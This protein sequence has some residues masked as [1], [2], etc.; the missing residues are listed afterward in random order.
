MLLK[1]SATPLVWVRLLL[2]EYPLVW[3]CLS[4]N[5]ER[6]STGRNAKYP[7]WNHQL[8]PSKKTECQWKY[9][10]SEVQ[11]KPDRN[12]L[13]ARWCPDEDVEL[14]LPDARPGEMTRNGQ[15]KYA[16]NYVIKKCWWK[17]T[18]WQMSVVKQRQKLNF[19]FFQQTQLHRNANASLG[20]KMVSHETKWSN[21]KQTWNKYMYKVEMSK[22]CT[23]LW[24]EAHLEVK[25]YKA[26]H[27]RTTFGSRGVEKMHAVVARST[28]KTENFKKHQGFRP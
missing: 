28:F 18:I 6:L 27:A 20:A 4:K 12:A 23:A 1:L 13:R 19:S 21:V 26:H 24:R 2:M 8:N 7:Q 3:K 9:V 22:K 10:Y 16:W 17:C 15:N 11:R 14:T 5:A 25:M